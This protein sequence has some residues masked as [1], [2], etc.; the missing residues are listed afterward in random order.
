MQTSK[1]QLRRQQ[2]V[3]QHLGFYYGKLDGIW[4]PESIAAK[5]QFE[6]DKSFKP[7]FPTNGLPFAETSQLPSKLE[8]QASKHGALLWVDGLSVPDEDQEVKFQ[9]KQEQ[10]QQTLKGNKSKTAIPTVPQSSASQ[11]SPSAPAQSAKDK[12]DAPEVMME[13]KALDKPT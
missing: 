1:R 8:W 12:Q 11:V 7:A 4:G 2:A 10:P 3:M 5:K 13:V 9:P 6:F